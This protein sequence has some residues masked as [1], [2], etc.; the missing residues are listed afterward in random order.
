MRSD[1]GFFAIDADKPAREIS[2]VDTQGLKYADEYGV[3][4]H[5]LSYTPPAI[6]DIADPAE[7][8]KAAQDEE[9]TQMYML[10]SFPIYCGLWFLLLLLL[11]VSFLLL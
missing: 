7:P 3:G 4:Y 6:Q 5:V 1:G 8:F 10:C 2:D 11:L 9:V